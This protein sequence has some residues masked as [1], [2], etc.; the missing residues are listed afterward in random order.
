MGFPFIDKIPST[1]YKDNRHMKPTVRQQVI[2]FTIITL[3]LSWGYEAFL[4]ST[5]GVKKFGLVGL[6]ALM[7]IPGLVSLA[8]RVFWKIGFSDAGFLRSKPKFYLW[9]VGLPLLLAIT[10]NVIAVPLGMKTFGP[11]PLDL[12]YPK[13]GLITVSLLFGIFG[14]IGEEIGWRGFLL[15]KLIEAKAPYPYLVSG[16]IWALWHA[17]LVSLGGYYE[18]D[19]P[20]LIALVYSFSIITSGYAIGLL[21]NRS[22]SV[23]VATVFHASHNFFFQ[24]AIPRLVFSGSGP[25]SKWWEL[26]GSDCGII[27]GILY[28]LATIYML[29]TERPRVLASV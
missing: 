10:T 6:I 19:S 14:A 22:R 15:P 29:K 7:W 8:L 20:A 5:D 11:I 28:L 2:V 1:E 3:A 18:V 16:V 25:N 9:V 26:V 12:L 17:P 4:I 23:W 27:V 13:I 21:R 24:L